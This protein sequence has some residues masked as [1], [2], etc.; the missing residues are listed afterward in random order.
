MD[1]LYTRNPDNT[2][3]ARWTPRE[4]IDGIQYAASIATKWSDAELAAIGL[5]R[6]IEAEPVPVGKQIVGSEIVFNGT[7]FQWQN[8]LEDIPLPS[9]LDFPL[10]PA[11][12]DA[13]LA[14]LGITVEQIDVAIDTA[15]NDP[16]Q[17]AFAKAK[18]RKATVYRRE[19]DL[20]TVLGPIVN[21]TDT[22]ID[23]A[24]MQAKDL[25]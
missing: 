5:F 23:E 7:C 12:F 8:T 1:Q 6:L 3:G 4:R 24:W 14:L 17:N 11:Q 2:L 22:Q 16:T 25:R 21:I 9:P 18:V 10:N 13:I 15:I 20:F 19:N